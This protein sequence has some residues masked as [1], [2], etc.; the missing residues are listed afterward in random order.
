[1]KCCGGS[2]VM[3]HTSSLEAAA[4]TQ[5]VF[6]ETETRGEENIFHRLFLFVHPPPRWSNI[7][8]NTMATVVDTKLYDILGVSPS[9]SE[10]ELKKVITQERLKKL[11]NYTL[12]LCRVW[13]CS[14]ISHN[15]EMRCYAQLA[16]VSC[17]LG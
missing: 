14:K 10:N 12:W 2:A 5:S 4:D 9:A 13:K 7:H 11:R 1:M 8:S 6:P 3:Q 15:Q 17:E 16:N